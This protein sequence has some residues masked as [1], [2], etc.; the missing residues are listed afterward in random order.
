MRRAWWWVALGAIALAGL[1]GRAWNLDV[2]SRQHQHP[3][4]R[5]WA[6]TSAALAE[7]EATG[8]GS[9]GGTAGGH[10]EIQTHIATRS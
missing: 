3:D 6:L 4:E 2:D 1:V 5:H 8:T 10:T 7:L 9:A